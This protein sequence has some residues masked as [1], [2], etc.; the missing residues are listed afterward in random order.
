VSNRKDV[1]LLE[2]LNRMARDLPPGYIITISVEKD[3]GWVNLT[4]EDGQDIDFPSNLE[5]LAEQLED[6]YQCAVDLASG[7]GEE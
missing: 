3:S 2:T 4:G 1:F 7:H 6:A 5:T